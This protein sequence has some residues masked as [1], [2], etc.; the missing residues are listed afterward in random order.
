M[1]KTLEEC[2][3][4]FGRVW[5]VELYGVTFVFRRPK[6]IEWRKHKAAAISMRVSREANAQA[7]GEGI[8]QAFEELSQSCVVSHTPGELSAM[9]ETYLDLYQDL[10]SAIVNAVEEDMTAASK[11]AEP[12]STKP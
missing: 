7:D 10:G 3:A 9:E 2:Q 4:Q 11:K 6:P 1:S 12:S 5:P 8:L